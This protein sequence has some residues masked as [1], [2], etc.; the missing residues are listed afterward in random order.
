MLIHDISHIKLRDLPKDIIKLLT[1]GF[2]L[3][4][5]QYN[6]ILSLCLEKFIQ[7]N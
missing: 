1:D 3:F 4:F 7:N 5:W 6:W 2:N